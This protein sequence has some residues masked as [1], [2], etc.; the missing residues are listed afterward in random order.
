MKKP[1]NRAKTLKKQRKKL[2]IFFCVGAFTQEE[3]FINKKDLFYAKFF[4][5][6]EF[7]I[8]PFFCSSIQ[9]QHTVAEESTPGSQTGRSLELAFIIID[10]VCIIL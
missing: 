10:H 7:S 8:E 3:N 4:G 2:Q 1:L 5:F 9:P 6:E